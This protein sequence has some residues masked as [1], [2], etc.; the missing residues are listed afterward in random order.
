M[1]GHHSVVPLNV[2]PSALSDGLHIINDNPLSGQVT[3][4]NTVFSLFLLQLCRDFENY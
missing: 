1:L 3:E 4:H 2:S